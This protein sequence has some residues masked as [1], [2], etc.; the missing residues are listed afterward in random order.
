MSHTFF[1]WKI[2]IPLELHQRRYINTYIVLWNAVTSGYKGSKGP[3]KLI[4]NAN[5][6]HASANQTQTQPPILITRYL[7]N[8][9]RNANRPEYQNTRYDTMVAIVLN[10]WRKQKV[11]PRAIEQSIRLNLCTLRIIAIMYNHECSIAIPRLVEPI[12]IRTRK[13]RLGP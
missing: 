5:R 9:E 7:H 6:S 2:I 8:S 12:Y 13:K 3:E 10:R 11:D 1:K 4:V